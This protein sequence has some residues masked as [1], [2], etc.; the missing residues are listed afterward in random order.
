M[1]NWVTAQ[2][3]IRPPKPTG[4]QLPKQKVSPK[5]T[6]T[7]LKVDICM[8]AYKCVSLCIYI[9]MYTSMHACIYANLYECIH[10]LYVY[11]HMHALCIYVCMYLLFHFFGF[12]EPFLRQ[13]REP[14]VRRIHQTLDVHPRGTSAAAPCCSDRSSTSNSPFSNHPRNKKL[15]L[16]HKGQTSKPTK[17]TVLSSA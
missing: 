14:T 17:A 7:A 6:T 9:Y 4:V 2:P 10:I 5:T 12:F 15:N 13:L 3:S 16:L 8:Y 11:I 1:G